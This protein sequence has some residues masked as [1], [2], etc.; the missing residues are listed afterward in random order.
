MLLLTTL[1][2]SLMPIS[3]AVHG[4]FRNEQMM[5]FINS[6][7]EDDIIVSSYANKP[8]TVVEAISFMLGHYDWQPGRAAGI[9]VFSN[10]SSNFCVLLL[11]M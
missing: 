6:S 5:A 4:S 9:N 3:G 7:E 2:T 1:H 10:V 11:T 8:Q